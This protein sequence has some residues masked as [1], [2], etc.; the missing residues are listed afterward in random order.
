[1]RWWCHKTGRATSADY[2][3]WPV[4][5][6]SRARASP[7]IHS[8]DISPWGNLLA[9]ACVIIKIKLSAGGDGGPIHLVTASRIFPDQRRRG[10]GPVCAVISLTQMMWP[11]VTGQRPCGATLWICSTRWAEKWEGYPS[12]HCDFFK[13]KQWD[14]FR[15]PQHLQSFIAIIF[16][17][18][19]SG[20]PQDYQNQ[21]TVFSLISTLGC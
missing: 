10:F 2:K 1:M 3:P 17:I 16:K 21:S 4:M 15:K 13:Y 11:I 14:D 12:Y 9:R 6:L 18:F 5:K 20:K 7:H 8:K 19:I